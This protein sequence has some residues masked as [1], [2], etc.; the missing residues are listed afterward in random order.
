[1]GRDHQVCKGHVGRNTEALIGELTAAAQEDIDG[2]L[3][4]IDPEP[5]DVGPACPQG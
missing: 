3:A 2:S 4:E 1:M 5:A